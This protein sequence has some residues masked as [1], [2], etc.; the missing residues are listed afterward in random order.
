MKFWLTLSLFLRISWAVAQTTIYQPFEADSAAEPRGGIP[1]FNTFLQT[2]LRKP[3][4]AEAKGE[5]GRVIVSGIVETDGRLTDVKLGKTFRPDCDHEALRVFKLFNAWKPALKGGRPVR[6]QVTM[7]ITFK[8]NTP[9]I[10]ENGTRTDYFDANNKPLPDSSRARYKQ[11][12]PIDSIGIPTGDAVVYKASK[13]SWKEEFRLPLVR[14]E[15]GFR[16]KSGKTGYLIGYQNA[17]SQLD[18]QLISVDDRGA[19]LRQAY[20]KDG[21]RVGAELIY[22]SNGLVAEKIE[23]FDATTIIN[24]WYMN[25]QIK[26][27]RTVAKFKPQQVGSPEQVNAYWDST[28]HQQIVAGMGRVTYSTRVRSSSDT[29]QFKLFL[30]EGAYQNGYKQGVWTG[31]Y[32]DGSYFYE[33]QYE[34]GICQTG[35]ASTM[36]GAMTHYTVVQQPPEFIGGMQAL[37]Q[38]L[39]QNLQY[40]PDAVRARVQGKVFISF[41][42]NAEGAVE[43]V[44]VLKGI[45][46]GA[47][48]EALRVVKKTNG[49]WKPGVQRGRKVNT[50]YNL[51]INFNM[52]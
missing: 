33:E 35:K 32:E 1:F 21:K 48:E 39:S 12:S 10:Y 6:Q 34:K 36:G 11:V 13:N 40:P 26:Q 27:V 30:E 20:F 45:G 46:Y 4:A 47:D 3:T 31:H 37:G 8:P 16:G 18:G 50:N 5:G 23:E 51:P 49:H 15:N 38:F 42:I 25:G 28:G 17:I 41:V 22:Y 52:P 24:S 7:P 44:R 14:K 43:N 2:N 29:T 19:L 9:F